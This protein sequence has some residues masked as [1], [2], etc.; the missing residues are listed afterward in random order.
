[1]AAAAAAA[2]AAV[3]AAANALQP[4]LCA[5]QCARGQATLQY[6]AAL[7]P[8]QVLVALLVQVGA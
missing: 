3:A 7:Q 1:M 2:A 4:A 8:A 6:S 5:D